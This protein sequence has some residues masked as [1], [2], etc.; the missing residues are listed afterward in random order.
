[1][2]TGP[3]LAAT[4]ACT[5]V[6]AACS[7]DDDDDGG[8]SDTTAAAATAPAS[9]A[10]APAPEAGEVVVG[11]V[12]EPTSLDIV[13]LA[14]A[15]LDQILLDNV[16]ETLLTYSDAGEIEPGLADC[17]RSPRTARCTRSRCATG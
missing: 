16:Y 5:L 2:R 9:D 12:L 10:S 13:T 4:I 3:L 14:G 6:V 8:S 7:G 17:P 15:A 11:A 1:M